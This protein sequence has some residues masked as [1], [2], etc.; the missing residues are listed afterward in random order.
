MD[1]IETFTQ[2]AITF[3]EVTEEPHF[4]RTSFR[5]RKKIF[6]TLHVKKKKAV[7]KL[8]E[9]DQ[10]IF[11]R[12]S[13]GSIHPVSNKWGKQGWTTVD[14]TT[15]ESNLLQDALTSAYSEVAPKKL[16]EQFRN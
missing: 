4:E 11:S 1:Y 3:P 13:K 16:S 14:L 8:S 10:D 6:A 5:I 12:M 2:I 7:L 9:I 15:V